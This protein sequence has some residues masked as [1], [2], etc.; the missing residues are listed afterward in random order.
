MS[1]AEATR[2]LLLSQGYEPIKVISWQ[3]ALTLLTLG[4]VEVVEEYDAEVR[5]VSVIVKVP[6]VVRLLR[7]FRRHAK[8]VKFSRINIY[9]RDGYKC[10]YCGKKCRIDE[11]TYDHVV[12]RSQGGK[13]T[14]DN[15]VSCCY[16]CNHAKANRT[17]AQAGMRLLAKPV[18]PTWVPAVV[19]RL[20][21]TSMPDAWRDY[22]YWTGEIQDE[23]S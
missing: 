18:R 10:Q 22:L 19:I 16:A 8:P 6:A 3:R 21:T 5:T 20:S 13:T 12:P 2:T 17:P 23:G 11:L 7:A 9:A 15:I 1:T 4:K 14:W